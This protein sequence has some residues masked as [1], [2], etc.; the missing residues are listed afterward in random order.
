MA[1]G[2]QGTEPSP[3]FCEI[4]RIGR[5]HLDD[6]LSP[7]WLLYITNISKEGEEVK[8]NIY[9]RNISPSNDAPLKCT[10]LLLY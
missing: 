8:L 10:C 5:R 1:T 3:K 6:A 2:Y 4:L 7:L 9:S